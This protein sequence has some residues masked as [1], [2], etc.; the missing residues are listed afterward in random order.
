MLSDDRDRC[1]SIWDS[2]TT[3]NQL[4]NGSG[5]GGLNAKV[6]VPDSQLGNSRTGQ[7]S[8]RFKF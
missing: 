6:G 3:G 1:A 2:P 7:V 5:P 4:F 8:L